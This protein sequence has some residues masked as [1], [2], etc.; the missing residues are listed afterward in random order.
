MKFLIDSHSLVIELQGFEVMWALKAR[1]T[2]EKSDIMAAE[3]LE[4]FRGWR[5]WE[6]RLPGTGIPG[7]LIAGSFWTDEGWDFLYLKDLGGFPNTFARNVLCI[8]TT[9]DRYRR[10]IVTCQRA[11]VDHVLEWVNP[12][13]DV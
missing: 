10:I 6:L 2:V 12:Q 4:V 9:L 8:E 1:V 7:V 3:Y 13:P 5:K 11:E